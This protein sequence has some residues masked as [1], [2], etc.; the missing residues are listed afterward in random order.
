[1]ESDIWAHEAAHNYDRKQGQRMSQ[2]PDWLKAITT[3]QCVPEAYSNTNEVEHFANLARM[4]L[5]S[6]AQPPLGSGQFSCMK[7][8][9]QRFQQ[10]LPS[11]DTKS[12]LPNLKSGGGDKAYRPQQR[13]NPELIY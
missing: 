13:S 12:L 1:M 7:A 8:S 6:T 10:L 11:K 4:W 3:D 5:L 9:L 2:K